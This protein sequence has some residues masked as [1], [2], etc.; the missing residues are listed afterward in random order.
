M[1]DCKQDPCNY[2]NCICIS[3]VDD[4]NYYFYHIEL[5][6]FNQSKYYSGKIGILKS[7][8]K[9]E[10]YREFLKTI[11][12]NISDKNGVDIPYKYFI[13]KSFNLI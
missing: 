5:T 6:Y 2:P 1:K 11:T 4:N 7:I 10:V 9:G 3:E 8:K 13:I 12:K